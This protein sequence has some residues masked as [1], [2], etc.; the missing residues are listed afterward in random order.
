MEVVVVDDATV[1]DTQRVLEGEGDA[2]VKKWIRSGPGVG[3]VDR[4][5]R[6]SIREK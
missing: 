6:K 4:H 5:Q 2:E 1:A 3:S